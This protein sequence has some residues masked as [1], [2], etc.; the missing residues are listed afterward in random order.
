VGLIAMA[1]HGRSGLWHLILGST[2]ESVLHHATC[3]L[4]LVRA[5]E[6]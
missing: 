5:T 1:T 6:E 4:L 2:T 3:P